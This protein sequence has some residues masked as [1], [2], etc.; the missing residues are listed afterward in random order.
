MRLTAIIETLQPKP[1]A[2]HS[3]GGAAKLIAVRTQFTP[4]IDVG[5]ELGYR[6]EPADPATSLV[7]IVESGSRLRG[8]LL[9]DAVLGQRQVVIKS[10]EA[11]YRKVQGVAGATVLGDGRVAFIL[12]VD[13]VVSRASDDTG[14]PEQL[15][16][17]AGEPDR[18]AHGQQIG[19]IQ[20]R[21]A[22]PGARW[23]SRVPEL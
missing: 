17:A 21:S 2:V 16:S 8:A 23:C 1:N 19:L 14:S 13:A 20:G 9:V 10:L 6:A 18:G 11:N 4:L 5:C 15:L 7:L 3:L 22:S 12:D